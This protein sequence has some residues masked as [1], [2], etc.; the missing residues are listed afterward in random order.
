M[1]ACTLRSFRLV[2]TT[3]QTLITAKDEVLGVS[4]EVWVAGDSVSWVGSFV[5]IRMY[6]ATL[7]SFRLVLTTLPTL[8]IAKDEVLGVSFEVWVAGDLASWVVLLEFGRV[9]TYTLLSGAYVHIPK[10][11]LGKDRT[12]RKS[13]VYNCTRMI[14]N[15]GLSFSFQKTTTKNT[16]PNFST[17]YIFRIPKSN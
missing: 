17:T 15:N 7:R 14:F 13:K 9:R 11:H 4:F 1:Y 8:I 12:R 10:S 5:G 2:L 3:P 16:A 6:V